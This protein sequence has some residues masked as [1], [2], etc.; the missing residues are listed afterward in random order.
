MSFWG[1][2]LYIVFI[3]AFV[4]IMGLILSGGGIAGVVFTYFRVVISYIKSITEEVTNTFARVFTTVSI[5]L[6]AIVPAAGIVT[7]FIL[8]LLGFLN[9]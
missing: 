5:I 2:I 9:N 1:I 7:L 8:G 4:F 6:G 3:L